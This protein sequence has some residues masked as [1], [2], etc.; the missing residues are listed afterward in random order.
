MRRFNSK[1]AHS[2]PDHTI[3]SRYNCAPHVS[4]LTLNA[5]LPYAL[6]VGLNRFVLI[7]RIIFTWRNGQVK[8]V[9]AAQRSQPRIESSRPGVLCRTL[10]PSPPSWQVSDLTMAGTSVSSQKLNLRVTTTNLLSFVHQARRCAG[11]G[12]V[13]LR[14]VRV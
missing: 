2:D 8:I 10:P 7:A 1:N 12:A 13:Y 9:D 3:R 6:S 5:L 11:T 4:R 14:N